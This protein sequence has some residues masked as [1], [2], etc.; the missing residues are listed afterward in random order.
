MVLKNHI[1]W[2]VSEMSILC[3]DTA[4][5]ENY[6]ENL[7]EAGDRYFAHGGRGESEQRGVPSGED[8][9]L[10]GTV[11]FVV[12]SAT[13]ALDGYCGNVA[14]L[15]QRLRREGVLLEPSPEGLGATV[16][17]AAYSAIQKGGIP[18]RVLSV[19]HK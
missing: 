19:V 11:R 16:S 1:Q 5:T 9:Q 7:T 4:M 14:Y 13:D 18:T 10:V 8:Q 3:G 6:S 12:G 15:L 2:T 17:Q